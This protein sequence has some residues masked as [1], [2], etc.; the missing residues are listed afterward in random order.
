MITAMCGR[1]NGDRLREMHRCRQSG[2]P[3]HV[4]GDSD[5]LLQR[6]SVRPL[7]GACCF[8]EQSSKVFPQPALLAWR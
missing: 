6:F 3:D 5:L 4:R 1:P 7:R 2:E 8:V